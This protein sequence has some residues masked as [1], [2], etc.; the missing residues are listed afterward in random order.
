MD[1]LF[2]LPPCPVALPRAYWLPPH[3]NTLATHVL[4]LQPSAAEFSRVTEKMASA[5]ENAYDMGVVNELYGESAV[6][7]PHR[8]YAMLS[9]EFRNKEGLRSGEG[10]GHTGYLGS[11]TEVWDAVAAYNKAKFVHF[12]D[13]PVPK[14]WTRAPE[15]VVEKNQPGCRNVGGVND[16]TE[17][18]IWN[19]LYADFRRLRKVS[20]FSGIPA[21]T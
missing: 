12:S 19:R 14:P 8:G 11:Y 15:W 10:E 4:L 20:S 1:E 3:S 21:Q 17:R 9:S 18:E 6:I 5:A 7:L 2:H 13:W 16:C